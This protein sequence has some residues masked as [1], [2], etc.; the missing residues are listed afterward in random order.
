MLGFLPVDFFRGEGERRREQVR[1]VWSR[2]TKRRR[3]PEVKQGDEDHARE[4]ELGVL[5]ED[6]DGRGHA[7]RVSRKRT[8]IELSSP[9]EVRAGGEEM[10]RAGWA[11]AARKRKKRRWA[12][13]GKEERRRWAE[14]KRGPEGKRES[15]RLAL[16]VLF[17]KILLLI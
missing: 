14:R 11:A 2:G 16:R 5:V 12:R 6:S 7:I 4:V 13:G 10:G 17:S 9:E 8:R 15:P 1:G 3:G